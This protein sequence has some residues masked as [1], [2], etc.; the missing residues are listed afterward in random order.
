MDD[1]K[2]EKMEK[3]LK[4]MEV[5]GNNLDLKLSDEDSKST[6]DSSSE[7]DLFKSKEGII[8]T[9]FYVIVLS[10]CQ[11][12]LNLVELSFFIYQQEN[13]KLSAETIQSLKGLIMIQWGL[14]PILGYF[15]DRSLDYI[16]KTKYII[17]LTCII[18]IGLFFCLYA[19]DTNFIQFH[20]LYF[21][22]ITCSVIENIVCEY[23]LTVTTK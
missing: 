1:E 8:S 6:S 3:A 2:L 10:I 11:G 16:G 14:K 20:L 12:L 4:P 13:L 18:K 19:A 21:L 5:E 23:I 22:V 17:F 7:L 15:I 9:R